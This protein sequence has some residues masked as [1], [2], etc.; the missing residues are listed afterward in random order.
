MKVQVAG[1]VNESVTD[2]PG[3]RTTIFFQGCRH[4]CAGCHNPQTWAFDGGNSLEIEDLI[5]QIPYSPLI[6]GI[7]LTGG[8][9]FFQPQAAS[10]LARD[11]KK[12]G[13]DVWAYT[14]FTWEQLLGQGDVDM[15]DLLKAC[16]VLVDG[17]FVRSLISFDLPFRGSSN[18][19]LILVQE[20]LK[21]GSVVELEI[22]I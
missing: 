22:Y 11:C 15:L 4:H 18:Q 20:S 13:K 21:R 12:R 14:G 9:P 6:K 19:R 8:D 10:A 17:P 5:S 2:G 1:I 7:T 3:F 16:D